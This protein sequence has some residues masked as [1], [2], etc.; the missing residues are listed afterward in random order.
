MNNL[1]LVMK[2][3][4]LLSA[5]FTKFFYK[6]VKAMQLESHEFVLSSLQVNGVDCRDQ[7]LSE[8]LY[9]QPELIITLGAQA[10]A[11]VINSRERLKDIHGNISKIKMT[12][13]NEK[14]YQINTMPLF[15]PKLLQTAP[16]MKRTA[17]QDMQKV[18][19]FLHL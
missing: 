16:N 9:F 5:G 1:F 2:S 12:G 3:V 13:Q 6:M 7:L 14:E 17:W 8:I 10:T 18:M 4:Y 11:Q 19:E 15:S